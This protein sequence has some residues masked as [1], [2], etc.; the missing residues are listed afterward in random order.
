MVVA[1]IY[2]EP[3]KTHQGKKGPVSGRFPEVDGKRASEARTVLRYGRHAEWAIP[4][5]AGALNA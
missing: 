4:A 3:A 5:D 2:L 1:K